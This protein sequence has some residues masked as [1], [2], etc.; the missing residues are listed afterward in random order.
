MTKTI[1]SQH[2]AIL[3][4]YRKQS[5]V[6]G[7]AQIDANL[8]WVVEQLEL[9]AQLAVVDVA[10]GTGLFSRAVAP[11]VR[12]VVATDLTPE[13]L[14]Q[15]RA[16]A[17]ESNLHNISFQRASAEALPFANASVDLVI[18]RYA[19]HHFLSPGAVFREAHRVVRVGGRA[20][21]VDMVA[22]EDAAIR[23]A[24]NR[25]E[26]IVDETHTEVLA[27]TR[28]A[29]ELVAA[30]FVVE[31][32]LSREVPM[33]FERWQSFLPQDAPPRLAVRRALEDELA[34]GAPTGL[35]PF[36]DEGRL[37]FMHTWGLAIG[38]KAR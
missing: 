28:L 25:L 7:R 24:Q 35:R 36:V 1:E 6:W 14:E 34:G 17:Q 16:R 2:Q 11:H 4:E 38:R 32:F 31:K 9:N 15:G 22:D 3:Q 33:L 27:P 26:R 19:V 37:F 8:Q 18:S 5:A 29:G 20:A 13:M 12:S 30:G 10:A 23:D 21:I